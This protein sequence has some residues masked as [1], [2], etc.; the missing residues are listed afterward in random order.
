MRHLPPARQPI[1]VDHRCP[2]KLAELIAL[3]DGS[4]PD[5]GAALSHLYRN[6]ENSGEDPRELRNFVRVSSEFYPEIGACYD[7]RVAAWFAEN[8]PG[9]WEHD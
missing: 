9:Q 2:L 3:I 5:G 6:V 8:H 4:L 1:R 7:R